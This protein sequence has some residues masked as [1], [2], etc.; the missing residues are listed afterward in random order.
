MRSLGKVAIIL[1]VA[2]LLLYFY[3]PQSTSAVNGLHTIITVKYEDGTYKT[4]DTGRLSLPFQS[5]YYQG[6]EISEVEVDLISNVKY[7]G[8]M[9]SYAFHGK[10]TVYVTP[11]VGMSV[12]GAPQGG[13]GTFNI[14]TVSKTGKS[15]VSGSNLKVISIQIS[16]DQLNQFF[17]KLDSSSGT[18]TLKFELSDFSLTATIDG[19]QRTYTPSNSGSIGI[20][21][22]KISYEKDVGGVTG[23]TAYWKLVKY[24]HF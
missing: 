3:I 15:F 23:F 18:Y 12:I 22:L 5:I 21:S 11:E 10:I 14:Y 1:V 24:H 20:I 2:T 4:I 13:G 8:T 16:K 6:E 17:T 9:S 7:T 19:V